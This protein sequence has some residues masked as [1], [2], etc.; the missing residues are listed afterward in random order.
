[1]PCYGPLTAYRPREGAV[2]RR[3]VFDAR[4]SHSGIPIKVPCGQCS[5]CRLESSRQWAMRCMHEKKPDSSF[6]T[7]TYADE[8]LPEGNSLS[9]YDYV[10]FLKRFR[11][12]FGDGLRFCGCGEYGETTFR[13]H[14]HFL[15][16]NR[17]FHDK[18][19]HKRA[20]SGAPLFTSQILDE[21]WSRD[22]EVLGHSLIGSVDF[23]SC[24]YVARYVMK[25]IIGKDTF[26]SSLYDPVTGIVREPPF[27]T[28]SRRPGLGSEWYAKYGPHA[29]EFDSVVF[30]GRE[31]RPPRFYDGKRVG[32]CIN[33]KLKLK[34][35]RAA[36]LYRADNTLRRLRVRECVALAK[37]QL[38]GR[39]L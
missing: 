25:K 15:L 34:R 19:F 31:V 28:M 6:V 11:K 3:L 22:G 14:Y 8:H 23:D 5:G 18:R 21:L 39:S 1:M 26:D 4:K 2:D 30:N 38:K 32:P 27:M 29:Y 7:L 9:M 16:L 24:C 13:P 17:D 35:R 12:R 33:D 36:L 10:C 20:P 37:L